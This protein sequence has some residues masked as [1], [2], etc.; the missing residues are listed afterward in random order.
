MLAP[1]RLVYSHDFGAREYRQDII[2][3]DALADPNVKAA[4]R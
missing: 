3:R 4:Y 1:K 2:N